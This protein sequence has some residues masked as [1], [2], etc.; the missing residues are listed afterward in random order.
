M[1][2]SERNPQLHSKR[3]SIPVLAKSAF[4]FVFGTAFLV[5]FLWTEIRS[6]ERIGVMEAAKYAGKRA[7]VCGQVASVN[8]AENTKGGRLF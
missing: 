7:K 3:S 8:Y 4:R 5:L 1:V 2:A 6:A